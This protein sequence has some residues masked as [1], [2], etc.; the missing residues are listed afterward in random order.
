MNKNLASDLLSQCSIEQDYLSNN[1][2]K[3]QILRC[4]TK[5]SISVLN[6]NAE[7]VGK[8]TI[9]DLLFLIAICSLKN[10]NKHLSQMRN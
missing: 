1:V 7:S 4:L 8:P 10:D 2:K 9:Y 6:F 5:I 3:V